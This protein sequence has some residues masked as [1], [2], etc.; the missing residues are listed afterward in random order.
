MYKGRL[1]SNVWSLTKSDWDP[2]IGKEWGLYIASLLL[3]IDQK[4]WAKEFY[5]I[6]FVHLKVEE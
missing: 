6:V 3:Y 4:L 2:S 1:E 5:A